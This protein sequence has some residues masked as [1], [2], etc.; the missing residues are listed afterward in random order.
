MKTPILL[1]LGV[2]P[3]KTPRGYPMTFQQIQ[4]SHGSEAIPGVR[5]YRHARA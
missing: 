3:D 1:I 4:L 2:H 5:G